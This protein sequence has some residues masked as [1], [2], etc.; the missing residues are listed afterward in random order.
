[1]IIDKQENKSELYLELAG[2]M[3]VSLDESGTVTYINRKGCEILGYSKEEIIGK[4]WFETFLPKNVVTE[5]KEVCKKIMSGEMKQ[6]EYYKNTVLTKNGEERIIAWHNAY[7]EDGTGKIVSTLSSGQDITETKELEEQFEQSEKLEAIGRLAGGIAH[8]FNNQLAIIMG[9]SDL[10]REEVKGNPKL[11]DYANNVLIGVKRAT[12]LTTQ[13]L[14]FARKGKYITVE[15]DIH[16]ILNEVISLLK[17]SIDKRIRLVKNFNNDEPTTVGDVSQLKNA[18]LNIALNSRDA[19]PKGGE[20]IFKTSCVEIKDENLKF[21][22]Q[23][24]KYIKIS[25]IDTGK[26]MSKEVQKLIF[27]PFF[28]TKERGV[29]TGMGLSAAYGTI[30]NHG[31]VITVNSVINQ[32]TEVIMYLPLHRAAKE[33]KY[34]DKKEITVP[35]TVNKHI[36]LVD[37]EELVCS[38]TKEVLE[39][40]NFRVSVCCDGKHAVQFYKDQWKNIDIVIMDLVMPE[41][42]GKDAF[43]LMKKINPEIIAVISS[44]Y[45]INGTAQEVLDLGAKGFI[46]KPFS[47]EQLRENI[48]KLF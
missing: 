48:E 22:I 42:N 47:K 16:D 6:V 1:M 21:K 36:L 24:G 31:G 17:H 45:S 9:Y 18:I 4:N 10:I 30:H 14:A 32:G 27:E 28:T 15:L 37:D 44:G 3:F 12:D 25:I 46:Q 40:L 19:L 7:V 8:D 43:I 2:V 34:V 26:G 35:E 5:V 39:K 38:M 41:L 33:E 29:G 13:L 11:L 23:D 20:I